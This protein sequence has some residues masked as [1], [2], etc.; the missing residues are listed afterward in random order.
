[1][2]PQT[3]GRESYPL[4]SDHR[5]TA[6]AKALAFRDAG[7]MPEAR[8][9]AAELIRCD[10]PPFGSGL[11]MRCSPPVR[12]RSRRRLHRSLVRCWLAAGGREIRTVGPRKIPTLSRLPFS[13]RENRLWRNCECPTIAVSRIWTTCRT[14]IAGHRPAGARIATRLAEPR[15][16]AFWKPSDPTLISMP[17]PAWLSAR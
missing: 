14:P 10:A 1:M 16:G 4:Q 2:A 9:W 5:S 12:S 6:L 3:H 11:R 13:P 8:E 7:K 15:V 17:G